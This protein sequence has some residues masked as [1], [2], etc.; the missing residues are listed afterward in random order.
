MLFMLYCTIEPRH[1]DENRMRLRESMIGQPSDIKILGSWLSV[2]Q[3]E[4]WVVFDAPDAASAA[5]LFHRWTDLN[6][7]QVTPILEVED[8]LEAVADLE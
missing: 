4:G 8:L 2:T 7:N 5:K 1:R 3:L 6:V